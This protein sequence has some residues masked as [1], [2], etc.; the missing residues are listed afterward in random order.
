MRLEALFHRLTSTVRPAL[1]A[2]FCTLLALPGLAKADEWFDLAQRDMGLVRGNE[3]VEQVLFPLLLEMDPFPVAGTSFD[4]FA[5]PRAYMFIARGERQRDRM[6]EWAKRPAQIAVLDAI[7]EIVE[8]SD[9]YMFA[10]QIG[11][12]KVPSEWVEGGLYIESQFEDLLGM[13]EYKYLDSM[14]ERLDALYYASGLAKAEAGNGDE[15]LEDYARFLLLSRMLLNRPS[16]EEKVAAATQ[17]D[18]VC[19]LMTD[20]VYQYTRPGDSSFTPR[21]IS[22][23]L[24]ETDEQFLRVR[25]MQLPTVDFYAARQLFDKAAQGS[26]RINPGRYAILMAMMKGENAPTRFGFVSAYRAVGTFQA[27]RIAFEKQ[28]NDLVADFTRRWAYTDLY[29]PFLRTRP[30]AVD[31]D[32]S[33]FEILDEFATDDIL[34]LFSLRLQLL[35]NLSGMR[36]ALGAVAFYLDNRNLPGRLV[37]IQP[38]FVRTLANNLDYMHYDRRIQQSDPLRYWVPIRDETFGPR[39]TPLPYP[40]RVVFDDYGRIGLATF[41][42]MANRDIDLMRAIPFPG[43]GE[44]RED[45]FGSG[46]DFSVGDLGGFVGLS[47]TGFSDAFFDGLAS[48][49]ISG[50][51]IQ[52][53]GLSASDHVAFEAY[54]AGESNTFDFAPIR[55]LLKQTYRAEGVT[56]RDAQQLSVYLAGIPAAGYSLD[57]AAE[58][59]REQLEALVEQFSSPPGGMD[60]GDF[61][62]ADFEGMDPADLEAMQQMQGGALAMLFGGNVSEMTTQLTGKSA[63]QLIDYV[64][65]TV[66][67]L[68]SVPSLREAVQGASQGEFLTAD[69]ALQLSDDLTD[70]LITTETIEPLRQMLLH[71]RE[72]DFADQAMANLDSADTTTEAVFAIDG[73]SFLLYSVWRDGRDDRAALIQRGR[74]GDMLYWPPPFSLYREYRN[75]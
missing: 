13:L 9:R 46:G 6:I 12:D 20:L 52:Q 72:T 36:S 68:V 42:R 45:A 19:Q 65:A 56:E 11:S 33:R 64:V 37:A 44:G 2:L 57:T 73:N 55:A 50:G 69:E 1:I 39:E 43:F 32:I 66:E 71:F 28:Y 21:G 38:R 7:Q 23:A 24:L 61:D 15:A 53:F 41:P 49:L 14:I 63:D 25:Q 3:S 58:T 8:E 31:I 75:R 27:D 16:S 67:R 54:L 10:V 70:V 5:D 62:P 22:D 4:Y 48:D 59:I 26:D 17:M 29:D 18:W 40:I 35:T 47:A 51:T 34:Q 60:F 74:S 30:V